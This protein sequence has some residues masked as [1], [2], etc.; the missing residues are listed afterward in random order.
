MTSTKNDS[1][2]VAGLF[3]SAA[4]RDAVRGKKDHF[5]KTAHLQYTLQSVVEPYDIQWKDLQNQGA[6]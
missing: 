2:S 4:E 5:N 1:V 6:D 3:E